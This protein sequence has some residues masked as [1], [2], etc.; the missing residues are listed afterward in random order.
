M[1]KSGRRFLALLLSALM[2]VQFAPTVTVMADE[3]NTGTE[4]VT[5]NITSGGVATETADDATTSLTT[6]DSVNSTESASTEES[7]EASAKVTEKS[8]EE[9]NTPVETTITYTYSV[10]TNTYS[11]KITSDEYQDNSYTIN[12]PENPV[13]PLTVT[14]KSGDNTEEHDFNDADSTVEVYG[15]VFKLTLP[16]KTEDESS[17]E[18]DPED[19]PEDDSEK[20]VFVYNLGSREI[21]VTEGELEDDGSYTVPV[22]DAAPFFPYEVQFKYGDSTEVRW[23]ESPDA[24]VDVDGHMVRLDTSDCQPINLTLDINGEKIIV[25]SDEKTFTNEAVTAKP[26]MMRA[27]ARSMSLSNQNI[28]LKVS[29]PIDLSSLTPV[30]L[31]RVSV[32]SILDSAS[33]NG[34]GTVVWNRWDENNQDY[35]QLSSGNYVNLLSG[36]NSPKNRKYEIVYSPNGDQT[37]LQNIRYYVEFKFGTDEWLIPSLTEDANGTRQDLSLKSSSNYVGDDYASVSITASDNSVNRK[38]DHYVTLRL[39]DQYKNRE[40]RFYEGHHETIDEIKKAKDITGDILG[41][42]GVK[43]YSH[44]N[45]GSEFGSR[46][47][48]AVAGDGVLP[49]DLRA[50]ENVTETK[51]SSFYVSG[52]LM[53][54][55]SDSYLSSGTDYDYQESKTEESENSCKRTIVLYKG[56][57]ASAQYRL[58]LYAYSDDWTVDAAYEGSFNSADDA[59]TSGHPDLKDSLFNYDT[60]NRYYGDFSNGRT[61]TILASDKSGK[62]IVYQYTMIVKEGSSEKPLR[63]ASSLFIENLKN[64]DGSYI[65]SYT[66]NLADDSYAEFNYATILVPEGTDLTSII[67]VFSN[68]TASRVYSERADGQSKKD[69]SGV[70][71]HDF[72]KGPVHYSVAAEDGKNATNYWVSV[73]TQSEGSGLYVNTFDKKDPAFNYHLDQD[74]VKYATRDMRI[75]SAHGNVHD[76][77]LINRDSKE[78]SGLNVSLESDQLEMDPYFTLKNATLKEFNFNSISEG[79]YDY[80]ISDY[81]PDVIPNVAKIRLKKKDG[82]KGGSDISGKL[83]ISQGSTPLI[84]LTLTGTAGDPTITTE[85]IP[86]AVKYVPYGSFIQNNNKY[87]SNKI[88]YSCYG[89]LPEGVTLKQNGE[90]YGVPKVTGTFQFM[91]SLKVNGT[92]TDRKTYTLNVKDNTDPNVEGATD[93]GYQLLERVGD[94]SDTDTAT[95]YIMRSNGVLPE[96]KYFYIDGQKL[97]E[98]TDYQATSGSTIITI[99]ANVLKSLPTGTHTLAIEFREK[100]DENKQLKRAAQNIR[101]RNSQN[102]SGNNSG[103]SSSDSGSSDSG[104]SD[105]S[106]SSDSASKATW[107]PVSTAQKKQQVVVSQ[108]ADTQAVEPAPVQNG[109]AA[110][111]QSLQYQVRKGDTLM[112]IAGMYYGNTELWT[113]IYADNRAIIRNP[114]LIYPGQTIVINFTQA[115]LDSMAG[116][117]KVATDVGNADLA[118]QDAST[119]TEYIVL[120]GD[121]LRK[122]AAEVYGDESQWKKIFEANRDKIRKAN[123]IYAGQKLTIP[124]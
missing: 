60:S 46:W 26:R 16:E 68:S 24:S 97:T 75:D 21:E 110:I 119:I 43:L 25:H 66:I 62:Q 29:N 122:I 116:T 23:F 5:G 94:V 90:I 8:T 19:N 121:Y 70:T 74:G 109:S 81:D 92:E 20:A 95:E 64:K 65:K 36:M 117:G 103:N 18:V 1:K 100:G 22:T 37:S 39:A 12:V 40:V 13:F 9:H 59:K 34:N 28:E 6:E 91:I 98:G 78:L 108:A 30:E 115:M 61:F 76:I 2:T 82:V 32:S 38:T 63:A 56:G 69:E 107:T 120:P 17:A 99:H 41:G 55:E 83:T 54:K 72:S 114:D 44:S 106:G 31:T 50:Y 89:K 4:Y 113:R 45:S 124:R 3:V 57:N 123:L 58:H 11:E 111:V 104:S 51:R 85:N 80:K 101:V 112:K 53:H 86:E 33:V 15:H 27:M 67:P 49:V 88:T 35:E 73:I 77:V 93:E 71:S 84:V 7:V 105:N 14:F 10:G 52:S 87:S 48:T 42:S 118:Q 102:E 47:V 79:S 96:Y